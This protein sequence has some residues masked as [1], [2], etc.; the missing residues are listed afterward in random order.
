MPS[1]SLSEPRT[2]GHKIKKFL[3]CF[4]YYVQI[5]FWC[6]YLKVHPKKL[7]IFSRLSIIF[8][9]VLQILIEHLLCQKLCWNLGNQ[10][11]YSPRNLQVMIYLNQIKHVSVRWDI[12]GKIASPKCSYHSGKYS[13]SLST[14]V[15]H[16]KNLTSLSMFQL[17]V[18]PKRNFKETITDTQ[19]GSKLNWCF[20]NNILLDDNASFFS[21][22]W[23]HH[24]W[25]TKNDP[26]AHL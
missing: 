25:G 14:Y 18:Q 21:F 6:Y 19:I 23:K 9:W 15:S 7:C 4:Y 26:F 12:K 5:H 8:N 11:S 20:S 22:P 10:F 16:E 1:A 3:F 2:N 13:A 24:K 17:E